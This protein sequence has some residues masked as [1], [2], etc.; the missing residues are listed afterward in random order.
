MKRFFSFAALAALLLI[1][2]CKADRSTVL[3]VYNWSDYIDEDVI[4]EF[5][6]W[7][8]E[9]TGEK[10]QVIYQTFDINETMLSKIERGK[11]D[12]DVVCPSDYIIE[13]MLKNDLL[14]PLNRDF[15][16]TP[17]YIDD[18]LSPYI[19]AQF[20][21]IDGGDKNAND[22]AVGYMWGTTGILY[23]AKYVTDEEASTWD[24]IR[25]AKFADR[26]FIKD[27]PR[28]VYSQII[29]Y[30]H[31]KDIEEG[32]IT[33]DELMNYT[34]DDDI[35]AVEAYMRQVKELVA[36]WEADFGKDQMTQELGYVNLTWS[37][38]AVWAIEEAQTV[39]VDLRYVCPKEGFTV[40][41]DGW[42]I[43]KYAHNVKAASYW[44]NFMSRPDIVIRNVDVTGYVSASG[45]PEVMD[46]FA[47][48]EFDPIDVS[49]FFGPE[50]TA[51]GLDPVLYPDKADIERSTMEHDW[52]EHTADL[53]S[54]WSRV[55]GNT[56][57]VSTVIILVVAAIAVILAV[58]ARMRKNSRR[59]TN[60]YSGKRR[61]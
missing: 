41:F 27:S 16:D 49:Y 61:R 36:G 14:L 50:A 52:G 38:D 18:N 15:G 39:G 19:R 35:A 29:L 43:P 54:M 51:V 24:I 12:F 8:E 33:R 60:R 4:P 9:Q 57:N 55:K 58:V 32:R 47:S 17:N 25:N 23:N 53:V 44:I 40:W 34:S 5:E 6:Q 3:K 22:Y 31:Q 28:D 2:G 13:R 46:A 20:D 11:E 30:I 56:M 10:V 21:K 1:G 45:A 42:V 48:D 37:G 7:Y 26:I 59:H